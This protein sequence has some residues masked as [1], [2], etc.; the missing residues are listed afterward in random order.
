MSNFNFSLNDWISLAESLSKEFPQILFILTTYETNPIKLEINESQNLKV[1]CN[2]ADILNLVE[3]TSRLD[4]F[5]SVNTGNVHI[6]DN[7]RIP[8]LVI[9]RGDRY[10]KIWS[11]GSYGGE[12]DAIYLPQDWRNNYKDYLERFYQLVKSKILNDL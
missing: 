5:V 3:I 6:A 2:N 8:T 7:L 10:Q 11:G 12:F 4:L 1:F 9:S